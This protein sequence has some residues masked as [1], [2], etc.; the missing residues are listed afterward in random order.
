MIGLKTPLAT[1]RQLVHPH[2]QSHPSSPLCPTLTVPDVTCP[3]LVVL[4]ENLNSWLDISEAFLHTP[5]RWAVRCAEDKLSAQNPV[6]WQIP[7]LED[8][9]GEALLVVLEVGAEAFSA[10]GG[11]SYMAR[12]RVSS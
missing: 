7:F 4:P 9:L 6:G 2:H 1:G 5:A 3:D 10:E 11:P 8:A 12:K